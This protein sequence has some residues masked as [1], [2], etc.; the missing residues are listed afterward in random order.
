MSK[1]CLPTPPS[2]AW[3]VNASSSCI[4]SGRLSPAS[5]QQHEIAKGPTTS[6]VR[7]RGQRERLSLVLLC[8]VQTVCYCIA[9]LLRTPTL[10]SSR[11]DRPTNRLTD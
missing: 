11:P 9:K 8:S 4:S 6:D 5:P 7:T 10:S 3:F 2:L 1:C